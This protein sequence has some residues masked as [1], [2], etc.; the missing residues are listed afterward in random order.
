MS[1]ASVL[2]A[3]STSGLP[4]GRDQLA[5]G[6]ATP[7]TGLPVR[8]ELAR[9]PSTGRCRRG[10]DRWC[11]S[12]ASA[13]CSCSA[14]NAQV[15]EDHLVE[16][17]FALRPRDFLQQRDVFRRRREHELTGPLGAFLGRVDELGL[18]QFVIQSPALDRGDHQSVLALHQRLDLAVARSGIEQ[19]AILLALRGE[20]PA[21]DVHQTLDHRVARC[22]CP[23]SG[24][25]RPRSDV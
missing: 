14:S 1:S 25:E 13:R 3:P 12:R 23:R 21:A 22:P 18:D 16:R 11:L 5:P 9:I 24:R 15:L 17:P 10:A 4:D 19:L 2:P 6:P 8:L 7:G 20:H